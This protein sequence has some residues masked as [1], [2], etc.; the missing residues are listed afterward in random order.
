MAENVFKRDLT[1]I[2]CS[3]SEFEA[4]LE[5]NFWKDVSGQL[6]TWIIDIRDAL[7]DPD[8]LIPEKV[9]NRLG[10]N[11]EAIRRVL[12]LPNEIIDALKH[13]IKEI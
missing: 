3:V 2:V 12:V 1:H 5:S 4:G 8:G 6:E 7:E 10:G 11:A 13:G 9:L